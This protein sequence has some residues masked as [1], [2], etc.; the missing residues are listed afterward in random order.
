MRKS[1]FTKPTESDAAQP[2]E[3]TE[4]IP[5]E[6]VEDVLSPSRDANLPVIARDLPTLETP[7]SRNEVE[8]KSVGPGLLMLK[9]SGKGA[10]SET[11]PTDVEVKAIAKTAEQEKREKRR[12]LGPHVPK[13]HCDNCVYSAACAYFKSGY[14]C[15]FE[16]LLGQHQIVSEEDLAHYMKVIAETEIQRGQ[17][18]VIHERLNGGTLDRDT[19]RQLEVA[20]NRV[21]RLY[22]MIQGE[23]PR[24]NIIQKNSPMFQQVNA[25]VQSDGG[26]R[27]LGVLEQLITSLQAVPRVVGEE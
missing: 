21:E 14:V 12:F 17:L 6:A 13:I 7:E 22:A 2:I 23:K 9:T 24:V 19:S 5:V 25:V 10:L 8:V 26:S 27:Q 4:I 16:S 11:I 3:P 15:A 20:S 18:A 1:V